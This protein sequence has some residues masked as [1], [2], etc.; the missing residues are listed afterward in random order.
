MNYIKSKKGKQKDK[1][2]ITMRFGN[3]TLLEIKFDKSAGKLRVILCNVG[4][5]G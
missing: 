5:E 4:F 1:F 2:N 3:F